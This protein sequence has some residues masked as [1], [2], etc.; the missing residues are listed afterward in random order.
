MLFKKNSAVGKY[1]HKYFRPIH[2]FCSIYISTFCVKN[3]SY[4]CATHVLCNIH[5]TFCATYKFCTKYTIIFCS[6]YL[7][8]LT[9]SGINGGSSDISIF[10]ECLYNI[11]TIIVHIIVRLRRFGK[12]PFQKICVCLF[13]K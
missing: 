7:S 5:K 3:L 1:V 11:I 4:F 8:I 13:S 12:K 2:V 10:S 9:L 6:F